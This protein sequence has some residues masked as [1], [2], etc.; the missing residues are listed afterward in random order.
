MFPEDN[1]VYDKETGETHKYEIVNENYPNAEVV[2][3]SHLANYD[4]T[5]G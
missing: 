3:N 4:M 1:L 5:S 2:L